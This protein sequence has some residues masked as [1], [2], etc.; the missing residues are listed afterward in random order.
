MCTCT[1]DL[2]AD[3]N[4]EH[5]SSGEIERRPRR[6]AVART[7]PVKSIIS[8]IRLRLTVILRQINESTERKETAW[9]VS[10]NEKMMH[11]VGVIKEDS[12]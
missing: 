10:A 12:R 5:G 11:V 6:R 7:V 9:M 2:L 8:K 3:G 4:V 1:T